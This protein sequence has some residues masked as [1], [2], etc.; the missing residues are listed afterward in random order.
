MAGSAA[1]VRTLEQLADLR[2]RDVDRLVTELAA[3]QQ[4]RQR[5]LRNL[6][7]LDDLTVSAGPS[8]AL[9]LAL[10]GVCADYKLSLMQLS[11]QHS[12]DL[13]R[14]EAGMDRTRAALQLA[15]Q[16]KEV[17]EHVRGREQAAVDEAKARSEQKAQDELASQVWQ[18][19]SAG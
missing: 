11:S 8:G 3:Q 14:H 16:R 15:T 18:R 1:K 5:Y 17:M 6:S 4:T 13:K 10:S 9:P 12:E 19:R 2:Q 7:K